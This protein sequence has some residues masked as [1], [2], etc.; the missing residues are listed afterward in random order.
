MPSS[1][2]QV[3]SFF[4]RPWHDSWTFDDSP[5]LSRVS[6][7]LVFTT[8]GR[9]EVDVARPATRMDLNGLV[10][11]CRQVAF[12]SGPANGTVGQVRGRE[13][14]RVPSG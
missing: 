11:V 1:Q 2:Q 12:D 6:P 10:L 7:V 14:L 8:D 3:F 9:W 4:P 5:G 13:Y